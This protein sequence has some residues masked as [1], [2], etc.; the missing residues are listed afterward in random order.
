MN[1][2]IENAPPPFWNFS[3][4]SSVLEEVGIPNCS[5]LYWSQA[6][7]QMKYSAAIPTWMDQTC[8]HP[9]FRNISAYHQL[10]RLTQ[11]QRYT[12]QITDAGE[13]MGGIPCHKVSTL[14]CGHKDGRRWHTNRKLHGITPIILSALA[15]HIPDRKHPQSKHYSF[16]T[17]QQSDG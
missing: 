7:S 12:N 17:K 6:R 15:S 9:S 1:F 3:E 10:C 2:W 5:D 16:S 14:V 8:R 13:Y 4:N 11:S